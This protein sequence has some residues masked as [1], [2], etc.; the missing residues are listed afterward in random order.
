MPT[1]SSND[2]R[3]GTVIKLDGKLFGV[4]WFQHHKPGKGNT[5]IRLKMRDLINGGVLERTIPADQKVESAVVEKREM[6][7]LYNDGENYVFMDSTSYDQL[8]VTEEDL[9]DAK[10]YLIEGLTA[11]MSM[12]EGRPIGVEL[13]AS[14]ELTVSHT[15]PGVQGDRVSGATKPAT[16][17]TGFEIQVPLFI[18][19]GEKI[20]VD[21]REGAY[22]TRVKA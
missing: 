12:Y 5:V 22:I 18:E 9:G 6:S 15:D 7:Y 11:T 3:N 2:I 13:P 4:I 16:L 14:V 1:I 21:T 19:S 17:E 8:P 20:K 10:N